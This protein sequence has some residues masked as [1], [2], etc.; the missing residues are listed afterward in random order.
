[1]RTSD[2]KFPI[3]ADCESPNLTMMAVELLNILKLMEWTLISESQ[4]TSE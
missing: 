1:M 2:N 4:Q 3:V